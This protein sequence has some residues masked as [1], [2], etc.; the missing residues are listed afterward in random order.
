[1]QLGVSRRSGEGP[2]GRRPRALRGVRRRHYCRGGRSDRGRVRAPAGRDTHVAWRSTAKPRAEF[3][4]D[5]GTGINFSDPRAAAGSHADAATSS[6][7]RDSGGVNDRSDT[8]SDAGVPAGDTH[9]PDAS[10]RRNPAAVSASRRT[11]RVCADSVRPVLAAGRL[12]G[13]RTGDSAGI[14]GAASGS[15]AVRGTHR[16]S[17]PASGATTVRVD[18]RACSGGAGWR[19]APRGE[20][21]A[22]HAG[23]THD[24]DCS[25]P[26]GSAVSARSLSARS[27]RGGWWV[28]VYADARADQSVSRQ[29]PEREGAAPGAGARVRSRDVLPAAARRRP[30]RR[31]AARAFSRRDQEVTGRVRRAGRPRLRGIDDAFPR[32]AERHSRRRTAHLLTRRTCADWEVALG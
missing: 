2:V 14:I 7:H 11:G 19:V 20:T 29:R 28:A 22:E 4:A 10:A 30:S 17:A 5:A 12:R 25:G 13:P 24:A 3:S 31:N 1:M 23:A 6:C 15:T 9:S 18:A 27:Q 26:T 16:C 21:R 8:V 32:R